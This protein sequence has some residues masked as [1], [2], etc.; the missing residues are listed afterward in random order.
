MNLQ[1][2]IPTSQH[3]CSQTENYIYTQI[4]VIYNT[5]FMI[6]VIE[7]FIYRTDPDRL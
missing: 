7:H 5:Y 4:Y 3:I 6:F 1:I 2:T